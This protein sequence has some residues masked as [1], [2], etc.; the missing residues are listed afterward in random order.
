MKKL[1]DYV[2]KGKTVSFA[3]YRENSLW[4]ETDCGFIFPVP[5]LDTGTATFPATD[6]AAMFMRWIR[7]YL[8]A[9]KEEN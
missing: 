8:E 2:R 3:Y 9:M 1:I 7:K 5:I 6:K 4:Y